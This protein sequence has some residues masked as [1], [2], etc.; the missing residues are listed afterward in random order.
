MGFDKATAQRNARVDLCYLASIWA[1]NAP[2][3]RLVMM[4][5]WNHWVRFPFLTWSP[6]YPFYVARAYVYVN[7][8]PCA[9][10]FLFD[11]RK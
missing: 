8:S 5:D 2:E 3:D 9:Q 1:P 7:F 6:G 10:V 11:D 4:L